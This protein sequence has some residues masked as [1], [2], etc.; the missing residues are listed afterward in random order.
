MSAL[1]YSLK[2]INTIFAA[3][4]KKIMSSFKLLK[5]I[6]KVT[7]YSVYGWIRRKQKIL[8]LQSI[9][10]M[11]SAICILYF[12]DD[13]RFAVINEAK[14]TLSRDGKLI[15][16]K[17][18]SSPLYGDY[19]NSNYGAIEVD[20]M[21]DMIYEWRLRIVKQDGVH[22]DIVFAITS[23]VNTY[24]DSVVNSGKFYKFW[25]ILISQLNIFYYIA[26]EN[27]FD[28]LFTERSKKSGH[29]WQVPSSI[30]G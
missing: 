20:S 1:N 19:S 23:N 12:R 24:V 2:S 26:I 14:M 10:S 17:Y 21:S 4:S 27:L 5:Q 16:N 9:P 3:F 7:K 6:D 29:T 25:G 30:T 8:N 11:I 22:A 18:H 15:T 13:E 28:L